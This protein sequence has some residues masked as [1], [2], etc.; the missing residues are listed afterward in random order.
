VVGSSVIELRRRGKYLVF[1]L[2]SGYLTIHLRMSGRL[3]VIPSGK[4]K[5]PHTHFSLRLDSGYSLH[6]DDARKFA[7]VRFLPE[8]G[9]WEPSLGVEPLGSAFTAK[10]LSRMLSGRKRAIKA[11]LLDQ[12]LIAG[13]GNI[14][15][16]ESLWRARIHPNRPAASLSG[17]EIAALR[18]AI[19]SRLRAGIA[20][21]GAAIDWVYPG[22]KFQEDFKV[23]GK[24]GKPCPRC[25][26]A[27]ERILVAQRG[28]H[29]CPR[30]QKREIRGIVGT[31][32]EGA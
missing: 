12:S 22:G 20:S 13:I 15:S 5:T 19:R 23:Y 28:T 30:C 25:G 18:N 8:L 7:R 26:T 10:A 17:E 2:D 9:E 27:V 4:R 14:Y 21:G 29:F 32:R 6:L 31:E 3:Y 24:R 1:Q 16:D 11:V